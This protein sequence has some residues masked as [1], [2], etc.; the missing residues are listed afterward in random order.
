MQHEHVKVKRM[1]FGI[2][3]E[4]PLLFLRGPPRSA[5]AMEPKMQISSLVHAA[6]LAVSLASVAGVA[7]LAYA[8]APK[9]VPQKT[10]SQPSG[11][12]GAV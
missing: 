2:S 5:H 12:D 4:S 10:T 8:D 7:T 11:M 6:V 9:S 1:H 3:Q